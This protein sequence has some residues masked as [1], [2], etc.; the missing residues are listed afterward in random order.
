MSLIIKSTLLL[1]GVSF[2]KGATGFVK[3]SCSF[4]SHWPLCLF[5]PPWAP[6]LVNGALELTI[7]NVVGSKLHF[8][9][10]GC[11]T[12]NH[13]FTGENKNANYTIMLKFV[14][15]I[16]SRHGGNNHQSPSLFYFFCFSLCFGM[17]NFNL[18]EAY[19]LIGQQQANQRRCSSNCLKINQ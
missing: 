10:P 12:F 8:T 14:Y 5:C 16:F 1:C 6:L 9:E 17:N 13:G 19:E 11:T 3:A 2:L 7:N 18:G 4:E 15:L